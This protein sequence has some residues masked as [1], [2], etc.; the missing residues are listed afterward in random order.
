[1]ANLPWFFLRLDTHSRYILQG[2]FD[3]LHYFI[4]N[5]GTGYLST[6]W[7]QL[8]ALPGS[9]KYM[10]SFSS[11][12]IPLLQCCLEKTFCRAFQSISPQILVEYFGPPSEG[13]YAGVGL[14]ILSPLLQSVHYSPMEGLRGKFRNLLSS[15]SDLEI[16]SWPCIRDRMI[17]TDRQEARATPREVPA[18]ISTYGRL[19]E[20]QLQAQDIRNHSLSTLY[21]HF[22]LKLSASTSITNSPKLLG[23]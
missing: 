23:N 14:N 20:E 10:E 7:L 1:L 5:S 11:Y 8:W 16:A 6:N 19:I 3:T 2:C 17:A 4:L 9:I 15:S 21:L 22:V 13:Q 18:S 12:S